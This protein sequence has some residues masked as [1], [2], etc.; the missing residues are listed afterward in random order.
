MRA[1]LSK[2]LTVFV[3][4]NYDEMKILIV[5][6]QKIAI[7]RVVVRHARIFHLQLTFARKTAGDISLSCLKLSKWTRAS[8]VLHVFWQAPRDVRTFILIHIV[9]FKNQGPSGT[10]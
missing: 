4:I 9:S 6:L 2:F 3:M 10:D 8:L 5:R 7:L 1:L